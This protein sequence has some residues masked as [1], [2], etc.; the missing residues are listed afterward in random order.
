MD[1]NF[2]IYLHAILYQLE[3]GRYYSSES[4]IIFM[5]YCWM[6][7]H[8]VT[9]QG[10][11]F[12]VPLH[13]PADEDSLIRKHPPRR[14]QRLEEQPVSP[15]TLQELQD[16]LAEAQQRRLQVTLSRLSDML[17]TPWYRH[18]FLAEQT[19][20]SKCYFGRRTFWRISYVLYQ[21]DEI[22]SSINS[23]NIL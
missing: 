8:Y 20:F 16:K 5:S 3:V 7:T 23:R 6:F 9:A 13:D 4:S 15:P 2:C 1:K 21:C 12:E 10:L 18:R 22:K 19:D 14:L 17:V 11:A